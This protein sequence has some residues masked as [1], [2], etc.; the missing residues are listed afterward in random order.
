MK[1][2]TSKYKRTPRGLPKRSNPLFTLRPSMLPPR[3]Y[4]PSLALQPPKTLFS[5]RCNAWLWPRTPMAEATIVERSTIC[6]GVSSPAVLYRAV[7]V[8]FLGEFRLYGIL[9]KQIPEASRLAEQ[10]MSTWQ[11]RPSPMHATLLL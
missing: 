4:K 6:R 3:C 5:L 2:S 1:K 7:A 9:A 8:A 10:R 11:M